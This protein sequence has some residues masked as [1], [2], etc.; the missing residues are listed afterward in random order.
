VR[1]TNTPSVKFQNTETHY[2]TLPIA[3]QSQSKQQSVNFERLVQNQPNYI[4]RLYKEILEAAPA[5]ARI[6]YDYVVNY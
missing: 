2:R 1:G 3:T 5:N 6:I 4:R